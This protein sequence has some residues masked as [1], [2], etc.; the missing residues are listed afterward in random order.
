MRV[1]SSRLSATTLM[2]SSV[3]ISRCCRCSLSEKT[4]EPQVRALRP[5]LVD[6]PFHAAA[7]LLGRRCPPEN[8]IIS[9]G[10]GDETGRTRNRAD[11]RCLREPARD[12]VFVLAFCDSNY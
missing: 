2:N 1:P 6:Q 5:T 7:I 3:M 4:N 8:E 9:L 10:D 12:C 11:R